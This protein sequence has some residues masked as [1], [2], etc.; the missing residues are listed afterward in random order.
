M[1]KTYIYLIMV[2]AASVIS[3]GVCRAN[4]IIE[5]FDWN[6]ETV[7]GW[8]SDEV[9]D[10]L[11]S[12]GSGAVDA[13]G[14]MK[15]DDNITV[16]QHPADWYAIFSSSA[17]SLFAGAWKSAFW[18]AFDFWS[19]DVEL[20]YEQVVSGLDDSSVWDTELLSEEDDSVSVVSAVYGDSAKWDYGGS[21]Q[22]DFV[23]EL[24]S[25]EWI[26]DYVWRTIGIRS[27]GIDDFNLVV[28]RKSSE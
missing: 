27:Y 14:Y 16:L 13:S 26:G 12:I 25:V 9:W 15:I 18:V 11:S 7:D 22:E 3:T 23:N 28:P 5:N 10:K 17:S 21:L 4:A 20:D 19:E 2:I 1:K 8:E 6:D 24:S